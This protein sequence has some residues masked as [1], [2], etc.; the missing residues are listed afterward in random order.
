MLR[1]R[2]E[3]HNKLASDSYQIATLR[4]RARGCPRAGLHMPA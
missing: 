3:G 2:P 4:T 1:L